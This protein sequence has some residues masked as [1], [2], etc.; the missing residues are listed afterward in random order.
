[1][2]WWGIRASGKTDGAARQWLF[3]RIVDE[4]KER[5]GRY[6]QQE[7]LDLIDEEVDAVRVSSSTR[8]SSAVD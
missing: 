6:N 3:D 8:D 7:I 1:M 2:N 4:V 5:N